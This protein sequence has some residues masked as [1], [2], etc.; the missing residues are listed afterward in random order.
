MYLKTMS[1][2]FWLFIEKIT[3]LDSQQQGN[4][5]LKSLHA[6]N[7]PCLFVVCIFLMRPKGRLRE[8]IVAAL[9]VVRLS[10]IILSGA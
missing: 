3:I 5:F 8:H 6:G 1:P 7:F 2:I 10:V 4:L 9:S